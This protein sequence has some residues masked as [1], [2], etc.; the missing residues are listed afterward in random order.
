MAGRFSRARDRR[1]EPIEARR[2]S[3]VAKA[4]PQG[5]PDISPEGMASRRISRPRRT[6]WR[7]IAGGGEAAVRPPRPDRMT[8]MRCG[9][10]PPPTVL[11]IH[12]IARATHPCDA[13]RPAP[14]TRLPPMD[15]A[16]RTIGMETGMA[17]TCRGSAVPFLG[18]KGPRDSLATRTVDRGSE[19]VRRFRKVKNRFTVEGAPT[20]ISADR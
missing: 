19:E 2:V 9:F 17:P 5:R 18:R 14:V 15:G 6:L 16:R 20:G 7:N 4:K 11:R 13:N 1:R 10:T 12:A 3:F 8:P